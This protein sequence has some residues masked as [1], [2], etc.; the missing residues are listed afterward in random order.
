MQTGRPMLL[1]L[2]LGCS[3]ATGC[4]QELALIEAN[5]CGN[6]VLEPVNDEDCDGEPNCRPPGGHGACRFSCDRAADCPDGCDPEPTCGGGPTCC[7][8]GLRCCPTGFACGIDAVCRRAS[9]QFVVAD[10]SSTP[11][12]GLALGHLDEDLRTDVVQLSTD[13]TSVHFYGDGV[14]P[15]LTNTF[16]GGPSLP[17]LGNLTDDELDDM[18]VRVFLATDF[19]GGV[20]VYRSQPDRTLASTTYSAIS[21]LGVETPRFARIDALTPARPQEVIL[22]R[23]HNVDGIQPGSGKADL[24]GGLARDAGDL[25]GIAVGNF[26]DEPGSPW[27]E[28]AFAY[29]G[30]TVIHLLEPAALGSNG[31]P[32]WSTDQPL[33][34][35]NPPERLCVPL[36]EPCANPPERRC[37]ALHEGSVF[38]D[39][40]GKPSQVQRLFGVY[41][42]DDDTHLDLVV[43]TQP[44]GL[45]APR[46]AIAYGM[47]DGTFNSLLPLPSTGS[48]DDTTAEL[49]LDYVDQDGAD[50]CAFGP[51]CTSAGL[52]LGLADLNGDGK[53]DLVSTELLLVSSPGGT[54]PYRCLLSDT[55]WSTAVVGHFNAN[56]ALDIMAARRDETGLDFLDGAGDGTFSLSALPS[57]RPVTHLAAG[58]FDGDLLAD[59][60][61]AHPAA[62]EA[63]SGGTAESDDS[64]LVS[65]G[66]AAGSPELPAKFGE[67]QGIEQ[68]LTG[69]IRAND[70]AEEIL[71]LTRREQG[72]RAGIV[73]G[74]GDRKLHAPYIF[75]LQQPGGSPRITRPLWVAYGQFFGDGTGLGFAAMTQDP[76]DPNTPDEEGSYRVWLARSSGSDQADLYAGYTGNSTPTPT[77]LTCNGCVVAAVDLD[78]D[79]L[80]EL[81]TFGPGPDGEDPGTLSLYEPVAQPNA[82]GFDWRGDHPTDLAFADARAS[83][84][85]RRPVVRDID[86]DGRQDVVMTAGS[87]VVI[88]WNVPTGDLVQQWASAHAAVTRIET[89]S[90]DPATD[91]TVLNTD[92][93]RELEL[94]VLSKSGVRLLQALSSR[95]FETL[96]EV[97][98]L[99]DQQSGDPVAGGDVIAAGDLDG[100][101]VEDLVIGDY[102][103][104]RVLRGREWRP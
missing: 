54:L 7:P 37:V 65:Y 31:L 24:L 23:D 84:T 44:S 21:L 20:A 15:T 99:T 64:V 70:A 27:Q 73:V 67:L 22:F 92:H 83:S 68:I 95:E 76:P 63:G 52:P 66:Q 74:S 104:Y 18:M 11:T 41:W 101:G 81:V 9:G 59:V 29:A 34:C 89:P 57:E 45:N 12:L 80:D 53:V 43:V 3:A 50:A 102:G 69:P 28:V 17:V 56:A 14:T 90:D 39:N 78:D 49:S 48:Q 77:E 32:E 13:T 86:R 16:L 25:V 38:D 94:A 62:V 91:V 71:I 36:F 87:E 98:P 85:V 2:V 82:L 103:S 88:F 30:D 58:D 96:T 8:G 79:Q 4:N 6:K 40:S 47:G 72:L 35:A 93:D 61:F 1:A 10:A 19:G 33:P 42:N 100:D 46:L 97:D 5:Q 75:Q 55:Q 51:S 60:V 26:D